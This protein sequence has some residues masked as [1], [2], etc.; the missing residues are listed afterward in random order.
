MVL[1]DPEHP[2]APGLLQEV[3]NKVALHYSWVNKSLNVGRPLLE[4]DNWGD[5]KVTPDNIRED[6]GYVPPPSHL[7]LQTPRPTP[8]G[9]QYDFSTPVFSQGSTSAT[10]LSSQPPYT[11]T[12]SHWSLESMMLQRQTPQLPPPNQ[13]A[14]YDSQR[15]QSSNT[16]SSSPLLQPAEMGTMVYSQQ[17]PWASFP[18]G[19]AGVIQPPTLEDFRRAYE[20]MMWFQRPPVYQHLAPPPTPTQPAPVFQSPPPPPTQD[21]PSVVGIQLETSDDPPNGLQSENPTLLTSPQM[22]PVVISPPSPPYH[23]A[24]PSTTPEPLQ[25]HPRLF[26]HA[27]GK[28]MMFCV[29]IIVKDRGRIAEILR[30]SFYPSLSIP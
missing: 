30:V 5:C 21:P 8:E 13:V 17:P 20:V 9:R 18:P 10:P 2:A 19:T 23:A 4:S 1:V 6:F 24:R 28:P 14:P 15:T 11:P 22:Q 25:T 29:P 12:P 16:F 3:V 7:Q 26:E 27:V